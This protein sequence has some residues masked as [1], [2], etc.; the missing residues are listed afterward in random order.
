MICTNI[1][2]LTIPLYFRA[3]SIALYGYVNDDAR[4][5]VYD[6]GTVRWIQPILQETTCDVDITKFPF[7]SQTCYIEVVF[8]GSNRIDLVQN[9]TSQVSARNTQTHTH[10]HTHTHACART[11]HEL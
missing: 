11:H 1:L 7:D 3:D 4:F 8:W 10:T 2:W 5:R 6:D 9:I